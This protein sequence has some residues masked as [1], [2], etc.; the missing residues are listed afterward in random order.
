M[1]IIIQVSNLKENGEYKFRVTA[2]NA[3]GQSSP[4]EGQKIIA[5]NPMGM[6]FVEFPFIFCKKMNR[7]SQLIKIYYIFDS[8]K[9]Y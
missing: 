6:F 9:N 4:L 5:K 3:I 8:Q 2:F 7:K 1:T